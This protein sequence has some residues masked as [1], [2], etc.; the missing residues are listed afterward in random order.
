[1]VE[2]SKIESSM[3]RLVN[4]GNLT[5]ITTSMIDPLHGGPTGIGGKH[6]NPLKR[7]KTEMP[8]K[9]NPN[10][11]RP[12]R[13]GRMNLNVPVKLYI[14]GRNLKNMDMFSKS[15]PLCVVFEKAQDRNEWFEIGRTEFIK[16]TLDPNFE[17]AIDVDYFFEKTQELKFEFIDDD[18]GDSDDPYYD[19][20]GSTNMTLSAIMAAKG[21]TLSKPLLVPGKRKQRGMIIVRAE[22]IQE[23]NHQVSFQ[24]STT[25][26]RNKAP[27]CFGMLHFYG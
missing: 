24:I 26:L 25:G 8:Q 11:D 19:I 4:D 2:N 9:G 22:S 14:S 6:G 18:G 7:L 16:D 1:M 23:S 15:D 5:Q 27:S 21:Q 12:N 3:S 13:R 17:K 20:I 10:E